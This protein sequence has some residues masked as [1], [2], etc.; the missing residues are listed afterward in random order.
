MRRIK[1]VRN[2]WIAFVFDIFNENND[3]NVMLCCVEAEK[4]IARIK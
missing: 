2:N 4:Q 3:F 1:M